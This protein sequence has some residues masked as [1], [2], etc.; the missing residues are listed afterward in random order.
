MRRSATFT[1][2][3]M[4]AALIAATLGLAACGPAEEAPPAPRVDARTLACGERQSRPMRAVIRKL[5][6]VGAEGDIARGLDLDGRVSERGDKEA[7][8]WRDF[9]D[10]D[11]KPGIDN[12]FALLLPIIRSVVGDGFDAV[13]L[14]AINEGAILLMLDVER[15]NDPMNDPCVEVHVR[16]ASGRPTLGAHGL[17]EAG[18]TFELN[19][20][21]AS[22]HIAAATLADG[23]IEAGPIHLQVPFE[24]SGFE[25]LVSI[26]DA[27]VRFQIDEDGTM[28][29]L[30]A[31]GIV[32]SEMLELLG[33][34]AAN[35]TDR[36]LYELMGKQMVRHADLLPLNDGT[37][38]CAQLSVVL[39][40]EATPA[41]LFA[42]QEPPDIFAEADPEADPASSP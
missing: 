14:R 21:A 23:W 29:G 39:E 16:R 5:D 37:G 35:P 3:L 24:L 33:T 27:T 41:F 20:E 11:G 31:G 2:R 32:V 30:I 26:A 7:C 38:A 42:D 40:F 15:R 18:Q 12:Q 22:S 28:R 10:P 34:I 8:G 19:E 36:P 25:L 4:S 6:F 9:T 1:A 17:I 13:I